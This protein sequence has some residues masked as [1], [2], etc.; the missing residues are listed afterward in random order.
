MPP[1]HLE[2][3]LEQRLGDDD[4]GGRRGQELPLEHGALAGHSRIEGSVRLVEPRADLVKREAR[5]FAHASLPRSV[6]GGAARAHRR[7]DHAIERARKRVERRKDSELGV[8]AGI[9]EGEQRAEALF[10]VAEA[11]GV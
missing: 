3:V 4:E 8:A 2:P 9:C 10:E 11:G 6:G 7:P 1:E 5:G